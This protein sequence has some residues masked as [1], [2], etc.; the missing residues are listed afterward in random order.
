MLKKMIAFQKLLFSMYLPSMRTQNERKSPGEVLLISF[1]FMVALLSLLRVSVFVAGFGFIGSFLI[2]LYDQMVKKPFLLQL[3]MKRSFTVS[4]ILI[5]NSIFVVCSFVVF[6][7]A[8]YLLVGTVI[9]IASLFNIINAM[10]LPDS[11]LLQEFVIII[12]AAQW[13]MNA[14]TLALLFKGKA[15]RI[16]G[17]AII[18]VAYCACIFLL[19]PYSGGSWGSNSLSRYLQSVS[20][21]WQIAGISILVT[22][23]F[24][25]VCIFLTEF[26]DW[27]SRKQGKPPKCPAQ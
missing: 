21:G 22:V 6:Y 10:P 16:A 24:S 23:V 26:A 3:P 20:N 5:F 14:L 4:G 13:Y 19:F 11:T 2:F 9:D 25:L 7:G 18:T 15:R 1:C 8:I 27:Y 17:I 12:C